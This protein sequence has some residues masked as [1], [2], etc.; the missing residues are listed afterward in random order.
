M[1][2][3]HWRWW[4]K[5]RPKRRTSR[6]RTSWHSFSL[7]F[8]H[9]PTVI[10]GAPNRR[11]FK[12][13]GVFRGGITPSGQS[14]APRHLGGGANGF[15]E[16]NRRIPVNSLRRAC[17]QRTAYGEIGKAGKRTCSGRVRLIAANSSWRGCGGSSQVLDLARLFGREQCAIPKFGRGRGERSVG[18]DFLDPI[19][20]LERFAD[21]LIE[22]DFA[23]QVLGQ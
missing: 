9:H 1:E 12:E 23:E 8:D 5:D 15:L 3:L 13:F 6:E 20:R 10:V 2:K 11:R 14:D 16:G 4:P 7:L 21:P 17:P 22:H 19:E 18:Q